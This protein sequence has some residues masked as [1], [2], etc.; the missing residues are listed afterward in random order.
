MQ[1][2]AHDKAFA[3]KTGVP[4]KVA[5]DFVAADAKQ[6]STKHKGMKLKGK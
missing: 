3:K 4:Q 6:A 2:A 5:R 1:A